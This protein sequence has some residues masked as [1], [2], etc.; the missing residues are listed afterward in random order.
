MD[1]E[2]KNLLE[3]EQNKVGQA[4]L[5]IQTLKQENHGLKIRLEQAQIEIRGLID[6]RDRQRDIISQERERL[7]VEVDRLRSQVSNSK[8]VVTPDVTPVVTTDRPDRY[9]DFNTLGQFLVY[10]YFD[11]NSEFQ[12]FLTA[13]RQV[14]GRYFD[15]GT[16]TNIIPRRVESV[17]A[18]MEIAQCWHFEFSEAALNAIAE[19]ME[20]PEQV[21]HA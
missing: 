3:R 19:I 13:I 6:E 21:E 14:P 1:F 16:K 8:K 9:I 20:H 7:L 10:S 5:E 18:M 15:Y 4:Y 17:E 2:L 11:D 12:S